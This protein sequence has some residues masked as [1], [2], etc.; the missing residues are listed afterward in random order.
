VFKN[1][2][3]DFSVIFNALGNSKCSSPEVVL[4]FLL[5]KLC[6]M[7]LCVGS[8]MCLYVGCR[9][10]CGPSLAVLRV[11]VTAILHL[12]SCRYVYVPYYD[13]C[14][15]VFYLNFVVAIIQGVRKIAVHLQ[16]VLDSFFINHSE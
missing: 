5:Q 9:C 7:C 11:E 15:L 4:A 10:K 2:T 3:I 14:L 1:P 13:S 8:K 6:K 16:K 12:K